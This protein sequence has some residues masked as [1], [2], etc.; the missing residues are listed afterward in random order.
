MFVAKCHGTVNWFTIVRP[1]SYRAMC[2]L[3]AMAASALRAT[4]GGTLPASARFL[5]DVLEGGVGAPPAPVIG[6][7]N[8]LSV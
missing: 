5:R 4:A 6:Y 3:D 1:P 7:T 8:F 2:V